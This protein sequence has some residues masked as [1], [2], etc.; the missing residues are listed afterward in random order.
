MRNH[1]DFPDLQS[2]AQIQATE[3]W[4][5][6]ENVRTNLEKVE[7]LFLHTIEQQNEIERQKLALQKQQKEIDAMKNMVQSL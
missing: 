7:E 1:K 6:S 5:V 3:K 4:D 2:H